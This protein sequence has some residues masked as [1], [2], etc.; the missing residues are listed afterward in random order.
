MGSGKE[1]GLHSRTAAGNRAYPGARFSKGPE[2]FRARKAIFSSS[3]S[4]SGEVHT[5]ETSC[6]KGTSLHIKNM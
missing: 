6:M 1:P 3:V 4:K 5:P 2:T